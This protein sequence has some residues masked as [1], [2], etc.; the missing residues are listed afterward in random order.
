MLNQPTY[1]APAGLRMSEEQL[2]GW[3]RAL[4]GYAIL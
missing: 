2:L 4:M 3:L 1:I